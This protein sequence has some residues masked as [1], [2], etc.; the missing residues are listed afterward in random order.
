VSSSAT[1]AIPAAS[2]ANAAT[3]RRSSAPTTTEPPGSDA[4]APDVDGA[5]LV[6]PDAGAAA[7]GPFDDGPRLEP[8]VRE[9][10]HPPRPSRTTPSRAMFSRALRTRGPPG[11]TTRRRSVRCR[12]DQPAA[13]VAPATEVAPDVAMAMTPRQRRRSVAREV[14]SRVIDQLPRVSTYRL[15]RRVVRVV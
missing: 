14:A 15:R 4:G 10:C 6:G 12:A 11:A 8:S 9:G 2:W 13:E 7:A 5:D 1:A 3:T